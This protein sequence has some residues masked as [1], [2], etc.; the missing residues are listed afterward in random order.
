MIRRYL[1]TGLFTLLPLVVTLWLLKSI[2]NTLVGIFAPPLT[3][4][5]LR[6][7]L[8]Q[9]PY[10]EL[11]FFSALATLLLLFLVGLLMGNFVGRQLLYWLDELMLHVPVVKAIYGSIKQLL[12]AIQS[13]QGGSFKEVVLVEW[14]HSGSWTLGFVARRDCAW[15]MEGGEGMVA[16]YIPTAPNPTSGYVV[17]VAG[18]RLKPVPYSPEQALTWAVS[19]GVVAPDPK[20]APSP[21]R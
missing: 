17:M 15:A 13:G 14:P 2:F 12:N 1:V 8:G 4:I 20:G 6:V 3:W 9:P 18:E 7:G 11:A 21:D 10:W 19:G 5:S 16:V